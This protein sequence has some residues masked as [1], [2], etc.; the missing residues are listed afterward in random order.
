MCCLLGCS[1]SSINQMSSY[2][3]RPL[4]DAVAAG[5]VAVCGDPA[6]AERLLTLFT[7]PEKSAPADA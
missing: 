1:R 2:G 6:A 3:G 7:L 5:E 4:A